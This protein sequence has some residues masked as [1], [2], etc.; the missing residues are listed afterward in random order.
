MYLE[1]GEAEPAD[2]RTKFLNETK[3]RIANALPYDKH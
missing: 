2:V 1:I 3:T